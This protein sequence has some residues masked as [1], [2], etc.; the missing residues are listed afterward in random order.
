MGLW[1]EFAPLI[2]SLLQDG[3]I[4][5][6]LEE[7]TGIASVEQNSLVVAA[8]VRDSLL[9]STDNET[10]SYFDSPSSPDILYEIRILNTQQRALAAR[11]IIEHGFDGRR[12]EE[13]ARSMKDYPRRYGERGWNSFDGNLPGDCLAFMYFRQAQEHKA[14][15][16]PELS[17]AMLEKALEVAETERARQR[18]IQDLE[19]KDGGEDEERGTVGRDDLVRVPVVRMGFGEV[20]ESSTVVVFPVCRAEEVE[21]APWDCGMGGEFGVVEAEKG[22]RRWVVLP[23]WGPVAGLRRGGVAVTFPWASGVLPWKIKKK[24]AEEEILVVVDRGLKEVEEAEDDGY[25]LVATGSGVN[26]RG[27]EGMKVER[28]AKLSKMELDNCLGRVVLVVKPP[29]EEM[30]DQISEEWD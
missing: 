15:S 28:G 12:A 3:F 9:Q 2:S 5:T 22:W 21:E 17:K 11:F 1:F 6:T 23:G 8:Q 14:S 27:A 24:D 10:V 4:S 29:R 16:S 30:N 13:L 25:Y 26:G 20:A 19:G 7:I 18:V